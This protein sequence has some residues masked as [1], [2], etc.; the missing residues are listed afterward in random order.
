MNA[1]KRYALVLISVAFLAFCYYGGHR[2]K[3]RKSTRWKGTL[4]RFNSFEF[5]NFLAKETDFVR[6]DFPQDSDRN[7]DQHRGVVPSPELAG[8]GSKSAASL[9]RKLN[10]QI[11]GMDSCFN[12]T[13]CQGKPFRVY[14]YPLDEHVPPSE[15]YSKILNTLKDSNYYTSDP[16]EACLFV[17]ALDTLDRDPLSNYDFVRNMPARVSKLDHWNGG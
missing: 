2:L 4:G 12:L 17:L 6:S 11:C 1:K 13:R 15:S 16:A 7:F 10:H 8:P 3:A 14:V 9:S 5:S